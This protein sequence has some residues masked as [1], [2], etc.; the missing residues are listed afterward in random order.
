MLVCTLRRVVES[1]VK[2]IGQTIQK[3]AKG[4]MPMKKTIYTLWG[5]SKLG[6]SQPKW[7]IVCKQAVFQGQR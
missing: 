6:M 2:L 7:V 5:C 4:G 3:I 1:L